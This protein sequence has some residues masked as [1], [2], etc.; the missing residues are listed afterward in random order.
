MSTVSTDV[1]DWI[2]E[3]ADKPEEVREFCVRH[4]I[5]DYV[6]TTL[7]MAKQCFS[8]IHSLTLSLDTD[9]CDGTVTAR[10]EVHIQASVDET[11]ARY[12]RFLDVWSGTIPYPEWNLVSIGFYIV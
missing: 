10:V 6:H 9:P 5:L 8:P 11:Y 4:G 2:G 12:Q 3:Y 1:T 7:E